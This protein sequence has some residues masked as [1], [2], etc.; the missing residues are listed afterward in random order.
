MRS[1]VSSRR[2]SARRAR[3]RGSA[4]PVRPPGES[5]ACYSAPPAA[6]QSQP[7]VLT[8]DASSR[9]VH[10]TKTARSG[11]N[12]SVLGPYS[13]SRDDGT[14]SLRGRT[15]A[16]ARTP[17][18]DARGH[19][20]AD[21]GGRRS[22]RR[23]RARRPVALAIGDLPARV[24]AELRAGRG[25]RRGSDADAVPG[26]VPRPGRRIEACCGAR[27][28]S[29]G[30]RHSGR[31][32]CAGDRRD[33]APGLR[34]ALEHRPPK[35]RTAAPVA[36]RVAAGLLDVSVAVMPAALVALAAGVHLFWPVVACV[37]MAGHLACYASL[38]TT[39]GAWLMARLVAPPVVVSAGARRAPA[40]R[41]R[42]R[43]APPPGDPAGGRATQPPRAPHSTLT[44]RLHASGV[45]RTGAVPG[46]GRG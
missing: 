11:L 32:R 31:A 37:A 28:R 6:A 9:P 40:H 17:R 5:W 30:A 33:E 26:A 10:C 12:R 39:P 3:P 22:L 13:G 35:T 15:Q 2:C 46:P 44:R 25:P 8:R 1:S 4:G 43:V 23:P 42:S 14:G 20:R 24:R 7:A 45:R 29:T 21:Q 41:E 36:R 18:P 16:D 19:R 34:L 27:C 38:G